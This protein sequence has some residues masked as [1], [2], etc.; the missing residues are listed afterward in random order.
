VL[1]AGL[2]ASA[3]RADT[4][5]ASYSGK[6]FTQQEATGRAQ[7]PLSTHHVVFGTLLRL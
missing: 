7:T 4:L 3:A 6:S 5:F 1:A 2:L